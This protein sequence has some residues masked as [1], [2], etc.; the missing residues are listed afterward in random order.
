MEKFQ[1]LI[2]GLQVFQKCEYAEIY[3]ADN[4]VCC[5]GAVSDQDVFV[6]QENNWVFD[7]INSEWKFFVR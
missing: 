4:F 7:G 3:A 5:A 2:A 1:S 6:L